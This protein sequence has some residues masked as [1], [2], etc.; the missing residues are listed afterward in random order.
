[1]QQLL[2]SDRA[3]TRSGSSCSY[4]LQCRMSRAKHDFWALP[5]ALPPVKMIVYSVILAS[6]KLSILFYISGR[7]WIIGSL[8]PNK[9]EIF[10]TL[11]GS[12]VKITIKSSPA[13][14]ALLYLKLRDLNRIWR[15]S[16][17]SSLA[18]MNIECLKFDATGWQ[19]IENPKVSSLIFSIKPTHWCEF[20]IGAGTIF[21]SKQATCVYLLWTC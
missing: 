9:F 7:S 12:S 13:W 14:T 8:L 1:M 6:A 4:H 10:F 3:C 5:P 21:L 16:I 2:W 18:T 11:F 19:N 17:V 15:T 20:L